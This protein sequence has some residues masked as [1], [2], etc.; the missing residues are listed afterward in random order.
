M[1]WPSLACPSCGARLTVETERG[2]CPACGA[3]Y[4]IQDR[5]LR[6]VTSP[7]SAAGY[8][9]HY[10]ATLPQVETSHFWFVAR[11]EMVLAA[12]RRAVPDLA[13]R[14]L[15]DVGCGSGGLLQFLESRGV[16]V[17]GACDAYPEA[18]RIAGSRS[19][20]PLVLVDEG[21]NP[22]LGPGHRLVGLFD[23]LEH[24]DDDEGTLSWLASVLE[25]GGVLALTVPAHPA[26]F[27]EADVLACHRRRYRRSELESKLRGA[28]FEIRTLTYFMALL[29]P[30]ILVGRRLKRLTGIGGRTAAARRDAELRVV[31]VLNGGLL[32]LL[33]LER[34][35]TRVLPLPFGTSLL[36]IAV[37]G[38]E[39]G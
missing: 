29:A 5:I 17:C 3:E 11:R 35:L 38:G 1:R 26:L 12:L 27:D 37:R 28:G 13:A 8:D 7:G 25:P 31:P 16:P 30:A 34:L 22:P 33:R 21:R 18:L 15:F 6:L 36:A 14:P 32:A 2:R 9:P 19:D 4:P 10:F 23:V 39:G 24:L 20:A